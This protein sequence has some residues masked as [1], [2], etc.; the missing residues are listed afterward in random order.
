MVP[1]VEKGAAV[2]A[3]DFPGKSFSLTTGDRSITSRADA[4]RS[5]E[6]RDIFPSTFVAWTNSQTVY[7][8]LEQKYREAEKLPTEVQ[9]KIRFK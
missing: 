3:C 4:R 7:R 5:A 2:E 1:K 8:L 6:Y 9:E